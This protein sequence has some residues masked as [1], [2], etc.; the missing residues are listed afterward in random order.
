[1]IKRILATAVSAI[2]VG[3]NPHLAQAASSGVYFR[4]GDGSAVSYDSATG[5]VNASENHSYDY[6]SSFQYAAASFQQQTARARTAVVQDGSEEPGSWITADTEADY[7]KDITVPAGI[8][9]PP[10][11]L[12]SMPLTLHFDGTTLA[13]GGL[14]GAGRTLS[15]IDT[16][17][18]FRV[19]DLDELV[20]GEGC[21]PTEVAS[22][23]FRGYVSFDSGFSAAGRESVARYNW[24]AEEHNVTVASDDYDYYSYEKGTLGGGE[25]RYSVDTGTLNLNLTTRTG[26]RLRFESSLDVFAQSMVS[27]AW[28]NVMG[29]F[30]RTFDADLFLP[31]PGGVLEGEV[32]G[33]YAPEPVPLPGAVWGMG[34]GLA[35][36][37]GLQR[38]ARK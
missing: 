21:R 9:G 27:N 1:M 13:G 29:D 11:T 38:R 35:L 4:L 26:H 30:S 8:F 14:F 5:P 7:H 23:G 3:A 19:L 20:C 15:S 33:V 31:A 28:S 32:L 12:I 6:G 37:A 36:L 17:F 16:N 34:A 25:T 22:F 24:A 18:S 10:G 2:L